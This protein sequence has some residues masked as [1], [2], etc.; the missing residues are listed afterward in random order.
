MMTGALIDA[1]YYGG[2]LDL[3]YDWNLGH[4]HGIGFEEMISQGDLLCCTHV[5]EIPSQG[6]RLGRRSC[7][8][9]VS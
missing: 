1:M 7:C 6:V 5:R 4:V 8:Y 2:N 3:L 9:W